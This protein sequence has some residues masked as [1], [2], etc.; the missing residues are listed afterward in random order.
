MR[1]L[2]TKPLPPRDEPL[3]GPSRIEGNEIIDASLFGL[4][5]DF[6][7]LFIRDNVICIKRQ[8]LLL[9]DDA[10]PVLGDNDICDH[11]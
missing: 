1:G 6:G 10:N 8:L 11:E 4:V 3:D 5:I 2:R 9:R 7:R